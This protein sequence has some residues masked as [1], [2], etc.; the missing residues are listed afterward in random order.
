MMQLL[1][2]ARFPN[3]SRGAQ[4]GMESPA[5]DDPDASSTSS[6]DNQKIAVL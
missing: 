5:V 1:V 4:Q 6:S 2:T 3:S